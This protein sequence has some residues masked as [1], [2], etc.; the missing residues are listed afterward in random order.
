MGMRG[1][2][3][4][5][6]RAGRVPG[7]TGGR[8]WWRSVCGMGALSAMRVPLPEVTDALNVGRTDGAVSPAVAIA[9]DARSVTG[10]I[11]TTASTIVP[12]PGVLTTRKQPPTR[13]TRS[14]IVIKPSPESCPTPGSNPR[15]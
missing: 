8:V 6:R 14:R 15:P 2:R 1:A 5:V 10:C 7:G 12:Q 11:G 9:H 13:S 3:V 4:S